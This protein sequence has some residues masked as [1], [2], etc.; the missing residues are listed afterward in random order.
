MSD[1][2]WLGAMAKYKEGVE[3]KEPFKGGAMQQG[4]VL[5][6]VAKE[7]PERFSRLA[8]RIPLETDQFYIRGLISGL[9]EAFGAEGLFNVIRRFAPVA[10]RDTRSAIA[11]A[12]EKRSADRIP[13]DLISLLESYVRGP[14]GDDETWWLREEEQTRDRERGADLH[15]GPYSSYLNS[16]RGA[17]LMTLMRTFDHLS[18]EEGVRRKWALLDLVVEADSTALRAGVVEEL[19]YLLN[20][21]RERAL[22]TFE[23]VVRGHPALLRSHF[24]DDFLYYAFFKTYLRMKPYIVAMMNQHPANIRQGWPELVCIAAISSAAME[25]PEAEADCASVAETVITGPIPWRRGAA[26]IYAFNLTRGCEAC[27]AALIRLLH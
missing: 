18:T 8:M 14:A 13:E 3:H 16:V 2:A 12:L 26:R 21:D 4:A 10:D 7:A 25:S 22:S 19:L 27:S 24:A 5:S 1:D 15:G 23:R 20:D 17:A 11:R 9:A 6:R